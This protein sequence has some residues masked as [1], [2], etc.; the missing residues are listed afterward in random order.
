MHRTAFALRVL[1][2]TL[3]LMAISQPAFAGK[4]FDPD[5]VSGRQLL[6]YLDHPDWRF[7]LDATDEVARRR[8]IQAKPQ[9][10]ELASSDPS[11]RVRIEALDALMDV[12]GGPSDRGVLHAI[13]LTAG[14][15]GLRVHVV[16]MVEGAPHKEDRDT[17][18]SA[19]D[20]V[21]PN[22]ARHAARALVRLGDREAGLILRDKVLDQTDRKVAQEFSE[23][24]SRLGA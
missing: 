12:F 11:D 5:V 2:L 20:D 17:L 4:A 8:I 21:D 9:L 1:V 10:E 18:L 16:K 24:A 13:I 22:V 6:D 3:G 15:E 7:R 23:A 14:D 19:L